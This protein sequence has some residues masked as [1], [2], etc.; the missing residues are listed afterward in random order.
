MKVEIATAQNKQ[1]SIFIDNKMERNV[2]QIE[3]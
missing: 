3:M 2:L 1:H